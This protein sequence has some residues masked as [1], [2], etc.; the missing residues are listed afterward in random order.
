MNMAQFLFHKLLGYYRITG[1]RRVPQRG[2]YYLCE[3]TKGIALHSATSEGAKQ[4][5]DILEPV[6]S[7]TAKLSGSVEELPV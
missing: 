5:R 4:K 1:V 3:I 6:D 7:V 2:D